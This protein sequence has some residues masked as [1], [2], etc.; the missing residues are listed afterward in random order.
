MQPSLRFASASL[1]AVV[2]LG[3]NSPSANPDAAANDLAVAADLTA[4]NPDLIGITDGANLDGPPGPFCSGP[5]PKVD[6]KA[7][8]VAPA[9]V[10]SGPLILNCCE[11]VRVRF[12]VEKTLGVRPSLAIRQQGLRLPAGDFDL[13]RLPQGL[14]VSLFAGD[15][16]VDATL[17]GTL[18]LEP[19]GDPST[20]T[21]VGAC[22]SVAAPGSPLDQARLYVDRVPVMPFGW[23]R[24]LAFYLLA[25]PSIRADTALGM[26]LA[27]LTL[28]PEPLVYLYDIAFYE[29]ST[30][31]V[32]W[33]NY[34]N[35]TA[36]KNRVGMPGTRGI[37][38]VVVADGQRVY[39]G[40]FYSLISSQSFPGP[41]VV[42]ESLL[43]DG[44]LIEPSYP[45]GNPGQDPRADPRILKVLAEA[46]KLAP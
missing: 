37:P 29:R 45:P 34:A 39:L 44:F 11:G 6:S 24:R 21:R 20:P 33:D 14:L 13:A 28:A 23:D 41:I 35:S 8:L 17:T 3:C 10:T 12:H 25:D 18:H 1:L 19:G 15:E 40:A 22:V 27:G 5:D 42:V 32:R 2:A 43:P 16:V 38:F 31:T 30:H 7:G 26:P 36:L 46:G 4:V 9:V